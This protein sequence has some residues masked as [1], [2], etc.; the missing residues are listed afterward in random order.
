MLLLLF[1]LA[2]TAPAPVSNS[3]DSSSPATNAADAALQR[4]LEQFMATQAP[5][6]QTVSAAQPASA[7]PRLMDLS[8]DILGAAGGSSAAPADL[9]VLQLGGHDPIQNGFTVQNVELSALGAVDPYLTGESHIVFQIDR[10]GETT[11]ELEEAFATTQTLPYGLQ[12]KAGMFFTEFGRLNP[13]HPHTWSFVDAPIVNARLL[14]PDGMRNPGV[15]L[16]WLTP[17]PWYSELLVTSQNSVGGTAASF[18]SSANVTEVAGNPV[19]SRSVKS[20]SD[21]MNTVRW[22]NS[23]SLTDTWTLNAGA[24]A[25]AGPNPTGPRNRTL[26]YGADVF[27]KW[28]PL[29]ANHGWPFVTLQGEAMQRRYDAGGV[30]TPRTMLVDSGS[31]AQVV[32][33]FTRGWTT[34]LRGDLAGGNQAAGDPERDQRRRISP[35]L[36]YYPSEFSKIRLQYN[37]E[38]SASL[39]RSHAVWAQLE[40]MLGAH[41]AHSF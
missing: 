29:E 13:T 16:S 41:P 1:A 35:M 6:A 23:F 8:L 25:A 14:G 18:L 26:L 24:S 4:E 34:G 27:A 12:L 11:A 31:Y 19:V 2:A 32:W 3:T 7:V 36:T 38:Y 28:A 20:P 10:Q 21:L 30:T 37:N 9:P 40:I 15:R 22:V 17:L 5:P 39:G 33:G